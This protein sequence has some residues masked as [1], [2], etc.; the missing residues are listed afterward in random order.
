MV[1]LLTVV[2]IIAVL[3]GLL[4]PVVGRVRMSART[5][6]CQSNLRQIGAA[7]RLYLV[8]NKNVLLTHNVKGTTFWNNFLQPYMTRVSS[9]V[10]KT[11]RRN[12]SSCPE[13]E[14]EEGKNM[15]NIAATGYGW[16]GNFDGVNVNTVNESRAVISW[17]DT[18]KDSYDGGFPST[19]GTGGWIDFAYRHGTQCHFLFVDSHVQG[20]A[21]VQYGDARD[22][23]QF[24]W[25]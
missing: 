4:I 24:D 15:T 17:D 2:A 5:A 25:K 16:N 23:K 12:V 1:E 10:S 9:A 21:K 6:T 19:T 18:N 7:N 3:A 14:L 22:Y 20:A 13:F 11:G 8:D